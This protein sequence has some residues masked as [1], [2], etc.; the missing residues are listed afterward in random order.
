ML[1]AT[2][3]K[4]LMFLYY[5]VGALILEAITFR[6]L[7]LGSMP[8][9]FGYNFSI[10]LFI[11]IAIF[12]V[13]NYT[14]QYVLYTLVLL[15]QA[16]FIYVNYSLSAM[17]SHNLFSFE[18]MGLVQEAT[19]AA[20]S[21][22]VYF[23]V[24]LQLI[25]VY[26]AI[27]ITGAIL[28]GYCKKQKVNFKQHFTIFNIVL[29]V[30]FECFS[31][32][33]FVDTR[34]KINAKANFTDQDYVISDSFYMN[35]NINKMSS[36][37]KFGT[38]GYFMNLIFNKFGN[39]DKS[40]KQVAVDY[41]NNGNVYNGKYID[42]QGNEVSD[43]MFGEAEGDNVIVIMMESLEWFCFGDGNY[44]P[45]LQ[46]FSN[47]L[48]PNI[49]NL[50]N[51]ENTMISSNFFAQS[52]TNYSETYGI[53]GNYPI[54][55]SLNE[56]I[57]GEA[58][59]GYDAFGYSLPY[60]MKAEGYQTNYV[61]SHTTEFYDRNKTHHHLGFDRVIGK[62]NLM[63]D[64]KRVYS[65]E[66][67]WWEHWDAEGDFARNAID[68]IVP[69]NYKE[70]PFYTFYLT[71]SSHGSYSDNSNEGDCVRYKNYVKYGADDCVLNSNGDYILDPSKSQDELTYT[72]WYTNV[73]KNYSSDSALVEELLYYQ[74]GVMGLDEAI[75]VITDK[76]ENSY[77]D[78]GSK[79][80]DNTTL[81][82]YS[83]HYTYYNSLSNRFKRI[84]VSD[85]ASVELN[86]I[87]MIISSPS[88]KTYANK[89]YPIRSTTY[90]VNERFCSAYDIIP[91]LLNMLGV[92]YN[93]RL[94]L[95]KS[96]FAPVDYIYEINGQIREMTVYYS[97]ATGG[98]VFSRDVYTY[99]MNNFI[100]QS[101]YV[102]QDTINIF[103]SA[104]SQL[105]K[106]INYMHII[107]HYYLFGQI[108][109]I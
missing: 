106:Q 78:D 47:E 51:S 44:D 32:G 59:K 89:L 88:I 82:L 93:E 79:L 8:E 84:P 18:M 90:L 108:T 80:I 9:Y 33:Y 97:N 34:N 54:T 27:I 52:K 83:D 98:G 31:C 3:N 86:I 101:V 69:T 20:T 1:K 61:H 70:K 105:L 46:N 107:N 72:S 103:K 99:D 53:V 4:T 5:I 43:N 91:T 25:S 87:P 28:L 56:N 100:K 92:E 41:F 85:T 64:G 6:I 2:L 63:K 11:A 68:E 57:D 67:T 104:S 30:S 23:S 75:G 40:L 62:N 29:L 94:Y 77:M 42:E 81:L 102:N 7:S 21:S 36:Y 35:T 65:E 19:A 26:L 38:Y 12:A 14:A 17:N 15:V 24:I 37:A 22:F 76:L 13:P 10:I 50:I 95:G 109:K 48:T 96:I 49:Y 55:T 60:R 74:C 16:I 66:D 71:V 39:Y 58:S 45:T 73:L